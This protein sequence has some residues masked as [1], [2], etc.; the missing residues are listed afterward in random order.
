MGTLSPLLA[1]LLVSGCV[2]GSL[3]IRGELSGDL[4]WEGIVRLQGD[5]IL[6][7]DSRLTI[8]PGTTILFLPPGTGEDQFTN[9]PN[10]PGSELIVRGTLVAEGNP[11]API[12]FRFV[13]PDAPPGSWGGINLTGSPHSAF[14]H[15]RFTQ[16]DS[17]LHSQESN[18]S[19]KESIFERNVVAIRFH[20]STIRVENNLLRHNDTAIRFHF[21]AP[22]IRKNDIR[23]NAKSF[24]I[25]SYPSDYTIVE[26]NILTSRSYSVVLGE[27]VP[28]D[29]K[30]PLN[31]WGNADS[32]VIENSF[33]DGRRESH[34]G[35]VRFKPFA[36]N[37]IEKAGISWNP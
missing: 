31:Y 4:V 28:E 13:D 19:V 22:L 18:V 26:N 15:C 29:V 23:D 35:T 37:P 33:F 12:T 11:S 17:A 1:L 25:T 30:M 14:R 3:P 32:P 27:D 20:S 6:P 8:A 10:F 34:L 7:A 16:A 24:F 21:G 36:T 5:V 9:H 2:R